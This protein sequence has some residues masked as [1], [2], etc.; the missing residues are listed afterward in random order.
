MASCGC[1]Q[2]VFLLQIQIC[3]CAAN[4]TAI[5]FLRQA[6]QIDRSYARANAL[7]A[8]VLG[9]RLN[10]GWDRME[11]RREEALT[12][13][14]AAVGEDDNDAWG[15]LALGYIE[16]MSRRTEPAIKALTASIQLNP[17]FAFAH[18]MLG[19]AHN[20]AGLADVGMQHIHL[21]LKLSPKDPQHAP[22]LS[23][24][25]LSPGAIVKLG[26]SRGIDTKRPRKSE[27]SKPCH[28]LQ[29][30]RRSQPPHLWPPEQAQPV[31]KKVPHYKRR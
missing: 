17:S 9:Q 18:A 1:P 8:W 29:L 11:D 6:L 5:A 27:R 14:H 15:Y 20:Y 30:T 4:D 21:A 3:R 19:M 24:L 22:Y 12:H 7:M 16:A 23:A 26:S 31:S 2:L 28:E 25:G 13:A 10:L